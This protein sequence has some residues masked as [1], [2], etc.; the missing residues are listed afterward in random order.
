MFGLKKKKSE[1]IEENPVLG[2]VD[3]RGIGKVEV[4]SM[5]TAIPSHVMLGNRRVRIDRELYLW[6]WANLHGTAD[7]QKKLSAII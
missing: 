2:Y 4:S 7:G 5:P 3:I 1:P 6:L